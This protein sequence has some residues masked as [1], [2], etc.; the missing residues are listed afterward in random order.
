MDNV[1]RHHLVNSPFAMTWFVTLLIA[2]IVLFVRIALRTRGVPDHI[3]YAGTLWGILLAIVFFLTAV[4]FFY[5][6]LNSVAFL[7]AFPPLIGFIA[8][9]SMIA[10]IV[11]TS[12]GSIGFALSILIVTAFYYFFTAPEVSFATE[13]LKLICKR[14]LR[15][16]VVRTLLAAALAA[17]IFSVFYGFL[18]WFAFIGGWSP[19]LHFAAFAAAWLTTRLI[20]EVAYQ[21]CAHHAALAFFASGRSDYRAEAGGWLGLARA[22][23]WNF[24]IACFNGITLPLLGPFYSCAH[25]TVADVAGRVAFLPGGVG[26]LVLSGYRP[27]HGVAVRVCGWVDR[28]LAWPDRRGSVYSAVF[29]VPRE[30]GCRRVAENAAKKYARVFDR[31]YCIDSLLGFTG[32]AIEVAVGFLGWA[33]AGALAVGDAV[34]FAGDWKTRRLAAGWAFF[35]AFAVL[36]VARMVIA[37]LVDTLFVCFTEARRQLQDPDFEAWLEREYRVATQGEAREGNQ[38]A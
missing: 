5:L 32:I 19:L 8:L 21:V 10:A 13:I 9:S 34:V 36:H 6:F 37:A 11:L 20:G 3:H 7:K 25:A 24:G 28:A 12:Y 27:V 35:T 23:G 15:S 33:I 38:E 29:G 2:M 31:K 16:S 1:K 17:S 18:T 14:F 26:R 22:L 30:E 4:E